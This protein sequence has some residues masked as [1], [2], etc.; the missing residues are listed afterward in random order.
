MA[1]VRGQEHVPKTEGFILASNHISYYDPPLLG[2]ACPREMAYLAKEELFRNPL[3]A[4]VIRTLGAH[5]VKRGATDI[6][7]LRQAVA[8]IKAGNPLVMFPEGTRSKDGELGEAKPGLGVIARMAK[9][10]IVPCYATGQDRILACLFTNRRIRINFGEPITAQMLTEFPK[11]KAGAL[12]I[13]QTVMDRI[14]IL[15]E[16]QLASRNA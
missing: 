14:K 4:W 13:S 5:P 11:G 6:A 15:K 12:E 2:T 8:V 3:F 1:Q 10:S 9:C 7:G 16:S